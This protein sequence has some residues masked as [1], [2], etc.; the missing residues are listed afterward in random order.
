MT[1]IK[2]N[3]SDRRIGMVLDFLDTVPI[4]S[5]KTLHV[6]ASCQGGW[7]DEPEYL[8]NDKVCG[9]PPWWCLGVLRQELL[10]AEMTKANL[11]NAPSFDKSDSKNAMVQLDKLIFF[12]QYT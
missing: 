2:V 4:P 8:A 3:V 7:E 5:D 12:L 6:S 10:R 9:D 1:S 11:R